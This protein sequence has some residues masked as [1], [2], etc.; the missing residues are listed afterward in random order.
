MSVTH[1]S[2][3]KLACTLFRNDGREVR[4]GPD[5]ADAANVVT[6][7]GFGTEVPGWG[8][9]E[10]S[11]TVKRLDYAVFD[12][13]LF[14]PVR[15]YD[16]AGQTVY[17]GRVV[18][19]TRGEGSLTLDLEGPLAALDDDQSARMIYRDTDLNSWRGI[20][21][22]RQIAVRVGGTR[23]PSDGSSSYDA[24][25]QM[26]SMSLVATGPW[27]ATSQPDVEAWYD[28]G[29]GLKV[30]KVAGTWKR[31]SN[32]TDA[33]W[34]WS[35]AGCDDD[36]TGA[37]YE[38]TG[39]LQSEPTAS[40]QKSWTPATPHRFVF[41]DF[42]FAGGAV[43]LDN[44]QFSVDWTDLAVYGDHGLPIQGTEPKAG[45]LASDVVRHALG[46]VNVEI[47]P[48]GIETTT[49]PIPHL[50]F[51]DMGTTP[52]TII[53]AVS[54][55]GA[56]GNTPDWGYYED[57]F[58]W[59]SPGSYGRT[60][61]VRRDEGAVAVDEGPTTEARCNGFIVSY[62]DANGQSKTVGPPGSGCD[63]ETGLLQDSDPGNPVN[64]TGIPR[65]Y[66]N[67]DIGIIDPEGAILV[68]QVL[69]RDANTRRYSGS[70]ELRGS[71]MDETGNRS[72]AYMV[73]AGDHVVV[74]DD[75]DTTPRKVVSTSYSNGS[76]SVTFDNKSTALESALARFQVA[77][78]PGGFS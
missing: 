42:I 24:S 28:A 6:E 18:K 61:R 62:S 46:R 43:A 29:P 57:G 31:A 50:T 22:T 74:E 75:E 47:S 25:T 67:R 38:S 4:F 16:E 65:R 71:V 77:S 9:A 64:A 1:D 8:F 17:E 56:T 37:G 49:Y 63:Q 44:V 72:P 5:E 68:G 54:L 59:R 27:G 11:V 69:L 12:Q 40:A 21:T 3:P 2:D 60:W 51:P 52:R 78:S 66:G 41:L 19:L 45:L 7:V 76:V 10:G 73:R 55:F 53:E 58:F 15:I 39:D 70:A 36:G 23:T 33:N 26:P 20:S 14:A 30:A 48:D 32:T 34:W 13:D 35:I